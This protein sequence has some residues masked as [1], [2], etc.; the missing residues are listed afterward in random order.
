MDYIR[1]LNFLLEKK[2]KRRI[3]VVLLV[4]IIGSLM[5]LVG[6]SILLPLINLAVNPDQASDNWYY[7]IVEYIFK[8]ERFEQTFIYLLGITILVYV[9]KNCYLA[10]M[11]A[12]NEKFAND[13]KRQLATRLMKAYLQEPYD[14]FLN[15]N[16]SEIIRSVNTDTSNVFQVV[17]NLLMVVSL[18]LTSVALVVYLACTN[19][20]LTITVTILLMLCVGLIL[21]G[22]RG[23]TKRWG[24][25]NQN[26]QG[27]LIRYV[28]QS[29]EGIKEIKILNTEKY[30][31]D[32]YN[33]EYEHLSSLQLKTK[34]VNVLPKYMI[35]T[36]CVGGILVYLMVNIAS[37]DDYRALVAQL[38]IFAVT[39][40]KLLPYVNS[41][42]AYVN[43]VIYNRA[44]IDLVYH[45]I[46]ETEDRKDEEMTENR[47]AIP[48]EFS[49]NIEVRNITFGYGE[50]G[51]N[52]IEGANLTI[53][54]GQAVA[55]IGPSGQGKTTM[56]D[57][58][59][60][61][62]KPRL[63]KVLVD[64]RDIEENMRGWHVH[65]GYIP[66]FIYLS[67][68]NIR[69][70]VAFGISEEDI[71]DEQVW[72]VLKEAQLKEFVQG[73]ENGLDTMVGERGTKLSGGQRQR[74]GIA[75]ALYRNPDFLVFDEATSALDN[76]TEKEV[77]EA[78]NSL[79]GSK[80]ML[81][82]AHRLSTIQN[83]DMVYKVENRKVVRER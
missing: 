74:I 37:G 19:L 25:E 48:M 14:F 57:I 2:T 29:F 13:V 77:M 61:I 50:T 30:Y 47:P 24:R 5:E 60:G 39:A 66:Q 34:L 32:E 67:D 59:L 81:I 12:Y 45:D 6:I 73:L 80:T 54:K 35:E 55:F 11:N 63:G 58:L 75:R 8:T 20:M 68:D 56:A 9:V 23:M 41:M 1:K 40:F 82:I 71:D 4:I 33:R 79:H 42:Y 62:L 38:A 31:L 16:S 72:N 70:N 46:R 69:K 49:Q 65:I 21:L 28:Q 26:S 18:G 3:P 43:T 27:K 17:N 22:V 83:C 76:E 51:R 10:W 44:S 53:E 64:G 36:V 7:R 52:V 15:K 78:I